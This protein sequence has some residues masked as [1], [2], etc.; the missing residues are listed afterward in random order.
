MPRFWEPCSSALTAR[1]GRRGDSF[2]L[3]RRLFW[4]ILR[5]G[6]PE[7]SLNTIQI[8]LTVLIL[9]G[10]VGRFG[11]VSL[12]G[13]GSRQPPRVPFDAAGLRPRFGHGAAGGHVR[14]RGRYRTCATGCLDRGGTGL[15][16][17]RGFGLWRRPFVRGS[18]WDYSA[19]TPRSSRRDRPT[20]AWLAQPTARSV[21]AW[22]FISR[23]R[24]RAGRSARCSRVYLVSGWPPW[25]LLVTTVLGGGLVA[26]YAVMAASLVAYGLAM[27][28]VVLRGPL[29]REMESG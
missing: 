12:A 28:A 22:R 17:D 15:G 18:G 8:N 7:L 14:R 3:E 20:S 21:W 24:E 9:T 19:T 4:E 10:L 16:D 27:A 26:V 1:S 2:V 29:H 23:R 25:A 13:Y 5:V 11:A 6:I